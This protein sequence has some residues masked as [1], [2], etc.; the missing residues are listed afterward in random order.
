MSEEA[1]S[2][3]WPKLW[4]AQL[5]L[6]ALAWLSWRRAAAA[7]WALP[8]VPWG[9]GTVALVVAAFGAVHHL[10]TGQVNN[11]ACSMVLSGSK[12]LT[13]APA[14]A[15]VAAMV[16]MTLAELVATG[17]ILHTLV[18]RRHPQALSCGLFSASLWP[19]R[20][21]V[22]AVATGCALHACFL[23]LRAYMNSV[24]RKAMEMDGKPLPQSSMQTS[25]QFVRALDSKPKWASWLLGASVI[26]PAY[27]ELLLPWVSSQPPYGL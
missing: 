1:V 27:E 23:S 10:V 21:W 22:P 9:G 16:P 13:E 11:L 3:A 6:A 24:A 12:S 8:A 2:A 5:G 18:L 17:T 4:P 20:S 25:I 19:L 14:C 15:S 7:G 26:A